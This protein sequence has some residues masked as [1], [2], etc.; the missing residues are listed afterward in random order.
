MQR[1][2]SSQNIKYEIPKHKSKITN[3]ISCNPV[4]MRRKKKMHK[5]SIIET[6]KSLINCGAR[7]QRSR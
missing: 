4:G 7:K 6:S 5:R 1:T 2:A 3:I